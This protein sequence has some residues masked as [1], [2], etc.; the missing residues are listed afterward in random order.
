MFPFAL[1][2]FIGL[3]VTALAMI[4]DRWLSLATEWWSLVLVVVGVAIAWIAGFNMAELW[5][6][7]MRADWIGITLTGLVIGGFA[8]FWRESLGLIGSV[9]RKV[10]DEAASLER[11]HDLRRIA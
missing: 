7:D 3:G 1:A 5:S 8:L 4:F 11:E 2:L 10:A 9:F 6:I